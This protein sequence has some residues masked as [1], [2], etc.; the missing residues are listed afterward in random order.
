M[1]KGDAKNSLGLR[2]TL[3]TQLDL[4][5]ANAELPSSVVLTSA[6]MRLRCHSRSQGDAALGTVGEKTN[7]QQRKMAAPRV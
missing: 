3:V 4:M 7:R 1:L 6:H 5:M 2:I